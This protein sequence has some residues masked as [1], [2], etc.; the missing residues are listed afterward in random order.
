MSDPAF[1]LGLGLRGLA[2][3][4]LLAF[5][6]LWRDVLGIATLAVA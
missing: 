1:V 5:Y 3:I 4:Q 6:S 2:L